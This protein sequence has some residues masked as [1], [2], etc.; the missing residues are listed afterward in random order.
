MVA[1]FIA[2]HRLNTSG[3]WAYLLCGMWDLLG[4]GIKPMS[5]ALAGGFCTTEPP[6]K[7]FFCHFS[8]NICSL[9][10]SVSQFGKCN[11]LNFEDSLSFISSNQ[12]SICFPI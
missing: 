8:N 10:V 1:F 12:I 9:H 2:E 6:R 5:P 4:I 11:I 3:A 7:P